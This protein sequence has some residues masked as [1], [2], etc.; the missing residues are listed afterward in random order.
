MPR[1]AR[2]KRIGVMPG[3]HGYW[4]GLLGSQECAMDVA[5]CG[6]LILKFRPHIRPLRQNHAI[7]QVLSLGPAGNHIRD[8]FRQFL[9]PRSIAVGRSPRRPGVLRQ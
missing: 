1:Q 3:Q 8:H 6:K 2:R 9:L 4:A 7:G 5:Q